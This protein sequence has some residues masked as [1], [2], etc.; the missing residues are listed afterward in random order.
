MD[1]RFFIGRRNLQRTGEPV[2]L[3][4][5][6]DNGGH[7][8]RMHVAAG[9]RESA[10]FAVGAGVPLSGWVRDHYIH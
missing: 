9:R 4:Y 10:V 6:F 7:V 2:S 3:I 8:R 1:A 5:G